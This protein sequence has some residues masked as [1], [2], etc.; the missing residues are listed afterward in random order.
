VATSTDDDA[1]RAA[2][3]KDC[4]S[5]GAR[6]VD[7]QR[8]CLQC[9]RRRGPLPAAVAARLPVLVEPDP[10]EKAPAPVE[11]EP[12]GADKARLLGYVLNPRAA[13]VAVMGM[14]AFGAL[15]GAAISPL[16]RSAGLYSILLEEPEPEPA[17]VE[18]E[19][20]TAEPEI[21]PEP[22][23]GPLP[24]EVS[25]AP[26]PEAPA[27]VPT[28]GA[29]P[30]PPPELP[31][32]EE[33]PEVKH[34]FLI[35]LGENGFEET[36]GKTSGAPY[37]SKTLARK[38]ELLTNYY[39]V[40]GSD[41]ANQIA[42]IS[43]QGPTPETA[44]NCPNYGDV[45]PGTES[46][47]GQVEG[48][49][50]VYPATTKTLVSQLTESK[51]SWRAYVESVG[52]PAGQ[53]TSCRHPAPG[54]PDPNHAPLPGDPYLTWRNPFVYFHSLTDGPECAE[55]DVGF[56]Q[57]TA[58]LRLQGTKAPAL[59]YIVP[60]ACHSGGQT[61]C[62][63]GSPV[64][65]AAAEELL[66]TLVPAILASSAY[67][68][69]GLIAITSALAPQSGEHADPSACCAAPEFRN[70]PP[71]PTPAE[72]AVG[73]VG[74][75]GG[76]GKVGMLLISPF[77]ES[78]SVNETGYFNHFTLLLTIEELFG[79]E[80]LGYASDLALSPFDSSVFNAEAVE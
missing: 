45:A 38:G 42:L 49:G 7:D 6:L 46:L 56:D 76:G 4:G 13:A 75:S 61:P 41:L 58:D 67:A 37:L 71:P 68:E 43:G 8:Y 23:E 47:E 69:G 32:T 14:L 63:P 15:L 57:L 16:A 80:K 54:A 35:V 2:R 18:A 51:L 36:F 39:G 31:P 74:P 62:E 65:P 24:A 64:G 34:V 1:R 52:D 79:L 72:P 77:V 28:E 22:E 78:G 66:K 27:E 60:N 48:N 70:L 19:E 53:A 40:A 44:A 26:V 29:P 59:S 5:C 17:P 50:C 20:P 12:V 33:L 11:P 21:E 73:P 10:E 30:E 9:G 3:G 55:D 25:S